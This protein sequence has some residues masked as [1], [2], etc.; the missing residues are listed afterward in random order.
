ME[1]KSRWS[2]KH[3]FAEQYKAGEKITP[4]FQKAICLSDRPEG[5]HL[6]QVHIHPKNEARPFCEPVRDG[7]WI[8]VGPEGDFW[9]CEPMLFEALFEEVK[10]KVK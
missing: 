5:K 7:D 6:N 2:R 8:I 9:I 4:F 1:I 3:T 10:Q